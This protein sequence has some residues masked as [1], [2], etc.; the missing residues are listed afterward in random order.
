M[1]DLAFGPWP[2]RIAIVLPMT[3][4]LIQF[5][6]RVRLGALWKFWLSIAAMET[7]AV[8]S[9]LHFLALRQWECML[10]PG[11]TNCFVSGFGS[12]TLPLVLSIFSL[13]L[14]RRIA[15]SE[16]VPPVHHTRLMLVVAAMAGVMIGENLLFVIIGLILLF[17]NFDYWLRNRGLRWGFLVIRD[18]YKDDIGPDD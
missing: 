3:L 14:V 6:G 13:L 4:A 17:V 12:L 10:D 1:P 9:L 15:R 11:A 8:L 7:V 5:V 18:D 16:L 2:G